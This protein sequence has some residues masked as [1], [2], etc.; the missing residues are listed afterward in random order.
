MIS[1]RPGLKGR[2]SVNMSPVEISR[3]DWRHRITSTLR[4]HGVH[5]RRINI[6]VTE[7]AIMTALADSRDDL[8][9][10]RAL[11]FGIHMD[12]FGTGY[13]SIALLRDLPVTGLKLDTSFTRNITTDSTARIL[14]S[15]LAGLAEGLN[16]DSIAEGIETKAQADHLRKQG[17]VHGQ[18]YLFGRPQP[19]PAM[20]IAYP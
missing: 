2:I 16:L 9:A 15:G 8:I 18:G 6:E 13:S 4:T 3:P 1:A 5:P 11:G 12:D 10:L 19:E 20:Q 7:T 14:A 17:W